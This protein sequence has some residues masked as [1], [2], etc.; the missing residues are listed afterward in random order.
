MINKVTDAAVRLE[1]IVRDWWTSWR[2]WWWWVAAVMEAERDTD[3]ASTQF[4]W[5]WW[6]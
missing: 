5:W 1:V 2:W 3:L 6:W 4:P